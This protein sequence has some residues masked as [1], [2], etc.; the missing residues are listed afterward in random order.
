MFNFKDLDKLVELMKEK[1]KLVSGKEQ[2]RESYNIFH[3]L[4]SSHFAENVLCVPGF[5]WKHESGNYWFCLSNL[6][7]MSDWKRCLVA[8][9][10]KYVL[11]TTSFLILIDLSF[12]LQELEKFEQEQ[13]W[14]DFSATLT[15][16][17]FFHLYFQL[18][19]STVC[20]LAIKNYKESTLHANKKFIDVRE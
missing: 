8:K 5:Y 16:W 9:R 10:E 3:I 7:E 17:N 1:M 18:S 13:T 11:K 2:I 6:I 12:R 15:V 20:T 19:Q 14:L 4:M